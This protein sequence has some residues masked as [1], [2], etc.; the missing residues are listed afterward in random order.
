M[1]VKSGLKQYVFNDAD[2]N[3]VIT[4]KNGKT[5]KQ[6]SPFSW[7]TADWNCDD[8]IYSLYG[9]KFKGD[10]GCRFLEPYQIIDMLE[11]G[12]AVKVEG[13]KCL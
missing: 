4:L 10:S 6:I 13:V 11:N 8:D 12:E 1:I 5:L 3:I 7:V 2:N 9:A